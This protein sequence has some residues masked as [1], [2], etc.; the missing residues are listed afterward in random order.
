MYS[1]IIYE[2]STGMGIEHHRNVWL[3][4][5][6]MWGSRMLLACSVYVWGCAGMNLHALQ[7]NSDGDRSR[8]CCNSWSPF[9]G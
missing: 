7:T 8:C 9:I 6:G 2:R 1:I 4:T 5:A 3:N